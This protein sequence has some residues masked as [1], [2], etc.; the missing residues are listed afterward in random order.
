MPLPK[1]IDPSN[2][3][4]LN[5]NRPKHWD[6]CLKPQPK[7]Y[8]M[9]QPKILS[10]FA[11]LAFAAF[12]VTSCTKEDISPDSISIFADDNFMER[13]GNGT[14]TGTHYN[15]NIIGV[16]KDKK[17][18]MDNNSGH[19]I[20]V[21]LE[22]SNKIM[23]S[24]SPAGEDFQV[25][26]ANGTDGKAGF[27]LPAPTDISYTIFARALGTPGGSSTMTTCA[28]DTLSGEDVCS[29]NAE[30]F[31]REKGGKKFVNVSEYLTSITAAIED[32]NG[33]GVIDNNDI[34]DY[35][36][37]DE[38]MEGYYWKYDN[39]GLKLLQLRFYY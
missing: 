20:F 24:R 38:A 11:F 34:A 18:D 26:D 27:Q 9:H 29:M 31:M 6:V 23:L 10:L 30:I 39:N 12:L 7:T 1:S 2:L 3:T 37:F 13:N 33:D 8:I 17:V 25:L 5:Q 19:R 36:I 4:G 22:G 35:D 28:T 16:P 15:L 14:P 32:L 21:D